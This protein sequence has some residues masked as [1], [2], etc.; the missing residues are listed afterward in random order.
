MS[1]LPE[2]LELKCIN[3][4]YDGDTMLGT[5]FDIGIEEEKGNPLATEIVHRY[6]AYP[7][8]QAEIQGYKE[9]AEDVKRL[10]KEICDI[11]HPKS[12]GPK[13]P[14]LCDVVKYLQDDFADQQALIKQLVE[15]CNKWMLV[16]SEMTNNT[17]CPDLALRAF[18]R[19][20]AVGLTKIAL[21]AAEKLQKE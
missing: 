2:K 9:W 4:I 19:R 13:G 15:A 5:F 10:T 18:Y 12:D 1:E 11:L 16:E 21:A 8:Q 7:D 6:N 14:S 17:P 20:Q 3:S